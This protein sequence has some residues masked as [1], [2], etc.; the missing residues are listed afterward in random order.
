M[1]K[2]DPF[3]MVVA[4]MASKMVEQ[5][6]AL[7][8]SDIVI[9]EGREVVDDL[10]AQNE[11]LSEANAHLEREC[12]SLRDANFE[13]R[14]QMRTYRDKAEDA[15]YWKTAYDNVFAELQTMRIEKRRKELNI[16]PSATPE[17]AGSTYMILVGRERWE[18]G[19][20]IDTIKEVR[21]LTGWG[22]KETK[23][24]CEAHMARHEADKREREESGPGT[25][26]SSQIPAGVGVNVQKC[27]PSNSVSV[28]FG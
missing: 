22:L 1:H 19:G 28:A 24:F 6:T 7:T 11:S 18:N 26:R 17:E 13:L 15:D 14:T 27:P 23:D 21:Q 5:H 2:V 16:A 12:E 8:L 3:V 25:K 4:A 10:V 20:K 9:S